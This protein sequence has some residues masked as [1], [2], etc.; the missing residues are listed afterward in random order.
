MLGTARSVAA[1]RTSTE[2][3]IDQVRSQII[4]VLNIDDCRVDT[5]V[6]ERLPT[7][8]DDG[9]VTRNGHSINVGR[10]G[11][12]VDTEI[13]LVVRSGGIVRGRFLLT[14]ATRVA[15]PSVEQLRIAVALADQVGAALAG[16]TSDRA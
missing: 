16:S 6:D 4:D 1:G 11:L 3:L 10:G 15:R 5:Y 8:A 13:V 9:T 14:A 2:A 12:P 7:I